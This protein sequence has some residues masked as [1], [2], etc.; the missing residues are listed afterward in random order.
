MILLR[1]K[2]GGT[3]HGA[4]QGRAK[5]MV[6]RSFR[7]VTKLHLFHAERGDVRNPFRIRT[8]GNKD[9]MSFRMRTYKKDG[10]ERTTGD[11]LKPVPLFQCPCG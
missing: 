2:V 7:A 9:L 6:I 1:K 3:L 10:R 4:P 8:Y 5:G 11:T